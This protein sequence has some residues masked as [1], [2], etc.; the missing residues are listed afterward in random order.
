MSSRNVLTTEGH[1]NHV[2]E[3]TRELSTE[4]GVLIQEKYADGITKLN[5]IMNVIRQQKV[6]PR[7]SRSYTLV[8]LYRPANFRV[9]ALRIAN[10]KAKM[11]HTFMIFTYTQIPSMLMNKM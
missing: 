11:S 1:D 9:G 3:V 2:S 6:L 10:Q 7:S 8:Q 5:A 4:L